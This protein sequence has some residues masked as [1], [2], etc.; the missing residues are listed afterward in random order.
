MDITDGRLGEF[1]YVISHGVYAWIPPAAREALLAAVKAHLAPDGVAYVSYNAHP[2]G[3]LRRLLREAALWH[4]RDTTPGPEQAEKARELFEF[5]EIRV[6][7]DPY[8][9]MLG[10]EVPV[11]AASP[12]HRLVHDELSDF[13][14]PVWFADFARAAAGHGLAYLAEASPLEL[15]P[16]SY[17]DGVME[18]L[19]EISGGDRIAREQYQDLLLFRRFR[20]TM[21]CHEGVEVADELVP[22][23]LRT[24]LFTARAPDED[25]PEGLRRRAQILLSDARPRALP[26]EELRARLGE[27]VEP[28]ALLEAI[29]DAMREFGIGPRVDPPARGLVAGERPRASALARWQIARQPEVTTLLHAVVRIDDEAGPD[30][31]GPARRHPRPRHDPPRPRRGGRPRARPRAARRQPALA[32]R[33]RAAARLASRPAAATPPAASAS[34]AGGE[35]TRAMPPVSGP[36]SPTPASKNAKKSP[37][38]APWTRAGTRRESQQ[39]ERGH[40]EALAG[41]E[42][43]GAGERDAAAGAERDDEQAGGGERR[44]E[45]QRAAAAE[46]VRDRRAERADGDHAWRRTPARRAPSPPS[47]RRTR[48]NAT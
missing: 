31:A 13:W 32:R 9:G 36:P 41:G 10:M 27:D 45:Q 47:R 22:D 35:I 12:Q 19:D 44:R 6:A 25:L 46:P 20:S 38:A 15:W 11:L 39:A 3:H 30:P 29:M 33:A 23:T 14:A 43:R 18:K 16:P 37:A 8:G 2:G 28:E 26:F 42:Q 21:L 4:S 48:G 7:E 24:L 40:G 1:D 34:A 17:P 5:L